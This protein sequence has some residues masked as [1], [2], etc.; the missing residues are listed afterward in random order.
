M[1]LMYKYIN[2]RKIYWLTNDYLVTND[3]L[4]N[5]WKFKHNKLSELI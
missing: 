2:N 4:L 5:G 1:I 3:L